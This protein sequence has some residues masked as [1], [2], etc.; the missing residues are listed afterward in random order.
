MLNL[1][2]EQ[3]GV[4][5]F[6]SGTSVGACGRVWSLRCCFPSYREARCRENCLWIFGRKINPMII[7]HQ[8]III[9]KNDSFHIITKQSSI[10]KL[11][12]FQVHQDKALYS[13]IIRT[14]IH[15]ASTPGL[16]CLNGSVIIQNSR[17]KTPG[18]MFYFPTKKT[19]NMKIG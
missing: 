15:L 14:K 2:K 3:K 10:P 17:L 1:S 18:E 13:D 12:L 16:S 5:F 19:N 7:S 4:T 6:A 8:K 9:C 11:R